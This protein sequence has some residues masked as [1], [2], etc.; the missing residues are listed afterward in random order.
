MPLFFVVFLVCLLISLATVAALMLSRT[1]RYRTQSQDLLDLFDAVLD[2]RASEARW[3]T[4]IG[5][6]IRHDAYLENLRRCSQHL[7]ETH[8]RPWQAAQGGSLFSRRGREELMALR[9][10]LAAHQALH[11]SEYHA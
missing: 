7:M 10:H 9:D 2:N 3:H 5:Y 8:G 4:L 11:G 6:P 1:P